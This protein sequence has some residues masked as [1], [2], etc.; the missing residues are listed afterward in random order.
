MISLNFRVISWN[1]LRFKL[2]FR[3]ADQCSFGHDSERTVSRFA[4]GQ[5]V[6]ESALFNDKPFDYNAAIQSWYNEVRKVDKDLADFYRYYFWIRII[7]ILI[8]VKLI[9][10]ISFSDLIL[11]LVIT[12]K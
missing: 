9:Y 8:S 2:F 5:S 10:L 1:R 4:V 6:H 7:H 11:E 12:L 3:W